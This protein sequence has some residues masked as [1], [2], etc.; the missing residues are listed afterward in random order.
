MKKQKDRVIYFYILCLV[1]I[2]YKNYV[3]LHIKKFIN[4]FADNDGHIKILET[5][6]MIHRYDTYVGILCNG[7][8]MGK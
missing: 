5:T 4:T 7:I 2:T 3:Y 6:S 8:R 1:H